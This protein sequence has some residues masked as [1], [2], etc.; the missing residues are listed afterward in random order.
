MTPEECVA[1]LGQLTNLPELRIDE[2]SGF[3]IVFDDDYPIDVEFDE[4]E[5]RVYVSA[6]VLGAA[7]A[8]AEVQHRALTGNGF[9]LMTAGASFSLDPV[10]LDLLLTRVFPLAATTVDA[11]AAALASLIEATQAWRE[12]LRANAGTEAPPPSFRAG[13]DFG[14]IRG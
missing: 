4:D 11:F 6:L 8:T 13:F 10:A 7:Q 3:Q 9:G 1:H 2:E 5:D 14:F 12:D